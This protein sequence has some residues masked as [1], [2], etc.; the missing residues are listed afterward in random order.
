M[1]DQTSREVGDHFPLDEGDQ[2]N[3]FLNCYEVSD[4]HL[5]EWDVAVYRVARAAGE[6]ALHGKRGEIKNLFWDLRGEFKKSCPGHGFVID[7]DDNSISVPGKWEIPSGIQR[8]GYLITQDKRITAR[9][10]QPEYHSIVAGIIRDGLRNHFKNCCPEGLGYLWQDYGRFCQMP[11]ENAEG[12]YHF[13]RRFNVTAKVLRTNRWV[14]EFAINTVTLD[15]RTL[16]DYYEQGSGAKLVQMIEAKQ[17][18]RLNRENRETAIRVWHRQSA[19]LLNTAR[20][21]ELSELKSLF[22]HSKLPPEEQKKLADSS[23]PCR[24]FKRMPFD[25]PLAQLRLVLDT[26]I[27]QED[28]TQTI[29][30]PKERVSLMRLL[31]NFT[32]GADLYGRQ[33]YLD[34]APVS[35]THFPSFVVAPPAVRVMDKTGGQSI[36]E[37]PII[38][39]DENLRDRARKR[40]HQIRQFGF[41]EKRPFFPLLACPHTFGRDRGNRIKYDLNQ[42]LEK[43]GIEYRFEDLSFYENVEAI[44]REIEKREFNALL[45]VLPEGSHALQRPDD[46]H[47]KIKLRI[48]IPSQCIQHDHTLPKYWAS[49]P[50]KELHKKDRRLSS[51]I[52]N[53]YELCLFNLL[54]KHHWIPFSPSDSFHY[55]THVGLD[56]GGRHNNHVMACIGHGFTNPNEGLVFRP[57]EIPL[58]TQKAEPI[59]TDY[60]FRGLLAIFNLMRTEL[61]DSNQ[62]CNFEHTLFFRD[63]RLNGD[64]DAWNE[65]EALVKLHSELLNRHWITE[66]SVWTAVEVLKRAEEWRIFRKC[67]ATEVMNPT[68][69]HCVFPFEDEE[70]ALVCTTGTPYLSQGTASPLKINIIQI[71]GQSDRMKVI[72]DLLWEADMCFTKL[73]IGLGLPWVLH[74][75]DIGALQLSRSYS[76]TGITL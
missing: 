35:T 68:V 2:A 21:L 65:L 73:D 8:A 24:E 10:A 14:V 29:I 1:R 56:V 17:M 57:E 41:L 61:L 66:D 4:V 44:R 59:P 30:E 70:Q 71:H 3:C 38:V 52:R 36:I 54:A 37:A 53:R 34:E 74:V 31:R 63:G 33:I 75:A 22:E 42:I 67:G 76:I 72:R 69:G 60:L 47:E 32:N 40:L 62:S 9:A 23:I 6:P 45:A 16:R 12:A 20:V 64:G 55:N 7:I 19:G 11:A 48:Q 15:R 46:T 28:H 43:Q 18:N 39:S 25:V 50:Q 51:N 26:Q 5:L 13:C 27:T 49:K 58:D